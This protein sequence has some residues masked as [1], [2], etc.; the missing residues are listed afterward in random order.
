MT[1]E[2]PEVDDWMAGGSCPWKYRD[3]MGFTASQVAMLAVAAYM[4]VAEAA[5]ATAVE[6]VHLLCSC[7]YQDL[8]GGQAQAGEQRDAA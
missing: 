7:L 2:T 5:P 1:D 4:E 3:V 8:L 6:R